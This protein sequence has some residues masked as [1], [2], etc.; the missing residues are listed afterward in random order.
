MAT[1]PK[2]RKVPAKRVPNFETIIAVRRKGAL[3][4]TLNRPDRLNAINDL[5]TDEII[6]AMTA[7]E[8]DRKVIAVIL[9]GNARAFSA[10]AD[11]GIFSDKPAERFDSYR[12]RFNF[13]KNRRMYR[14]VAGY[15][16]PVIS[17]VEGYCLGG[18]LELALWGDMIVAGEGAR[19]GLP[20]SRLGLIPGGGG[21]L[22]LPR[23]IGAP[24]AKEMMWTARRITAAEAREFRL[25]NHVTPTGGA[26]KKARAIIEEMAENG[27]L[28]LMMIK[29]AVDRG[30]DMSRTEAYLQ[31]GDLSHLLSFSEDRAEGLKAFGQK[32]SPRFKGQ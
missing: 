14:Y 27:P 22:N 10:G 16:K 2:A 29:Q 19:F 32:R 15:T 17:A 30:M 8:P 6:E 18:G 3:E 20:E 7:A 24:L 11:V 9:T 4:I 1:K 21:T 28:A 26:L 23:L 31:E 25:V 12:A 5:M 13:R